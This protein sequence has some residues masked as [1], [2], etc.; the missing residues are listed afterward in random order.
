M[1]PKLFFPQS[2]FEEI[3]NWP[4]SKTERLVLISE[5]CRRNT[6]SMIMFA[7]SGHIGTSLSAV[8]VLTLLYYEIMKVNPLKP[9]SSERD[10]FILSKGHAIPALYSILASKGFFPDER[11]YT[12][13]RLAGL[14]GHSEIT[15]PGVESNTGSLG[16]GL[17]KAQGH[18]ISFKRK[19]LPNRVFVMVGDGELQEG[20]NWEA[21][22]SAPNFKLGNLVMLIDKNLYQTDKKVND[23]LKTPS[24]DNKLSSQGWQVEKI[25]GHDFPALLK[26]FNTLD[27]GNDIP[28]AIISETIK[29]KGVSFMEP[30]PSSKDLYVWHGRVPDQK[31]FEMA[32][33]EIDSRIKKIIPSDK[34]SLDFLPAIPDSF[35]RPTVNWSKLS[36]V[37]GFGKAVTESVERNKNIIVLDADLVADFNLRNIEKEHPD[38]FL[39]LGIAEQNMVSIAGALSYQGW[40]PIVNTY[41][42][43][44]A[45]RS[46]EQIYNNQSEGFKVIYV[47]HLA[48]LIP[49]T[50]GKSHAG[51]RDIALMR[52]IPGLIL[53]EPVNYE[54]SYFLTKYLIEKTNKSSYL[55][56]ALCKG[57]GEIEL[58]SDYKVSLGKGFVLRE[59]KDLAIISYGPIILPQVLKAAQLLS[60]KGIEVKVINLPWLNSID[61]DWLAKVLG[62][63]NQLITVDNHFIEG[64]QGEEILRLMNS[65]PQLKKKKITLFGIQGFTES[66]Q[67]IETLYHHQLDSN[68]LFLKI[69]KLLNLN[70]K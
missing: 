29:G 24:L 62:P 41:A 33:D 58:P 36:V 40:L 16:M 7:G 65:H 31:E 23:I 63:I 66:G 48:G 17:S 37:D 49:A 69:Q 59:G 27:Y 14:Q 6:L 22:Q 30:D 34:L 60:K 57:L 8:D 35:E 18:A 70:K 15:T 43:F 50:P 56:L 61:V 28:K 53:A 67:P 55:R 46:N 54:E 13:R 25:S 32:L 2:S 47:G 39:E 45:S 4:L 11:L 44:L 20:Q 52:N 19:G 9:R 64:G 12:L 42:S 1:K 10:I 26:L 68:S 5:M 3:K 38:N 51:V 21:I